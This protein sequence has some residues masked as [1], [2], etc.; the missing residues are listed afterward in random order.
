MTFELFGD[1]GFAKADKA[2]TLVMAK[3]EWWQKRKRKNFYKNKLFEIC[4]L[5][6]LIGLKHENE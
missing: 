4:F 1:T 2:K 5:E 6:I 3:I